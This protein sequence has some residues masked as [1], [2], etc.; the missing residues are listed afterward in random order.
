M[1]SYEST[2]GM[3]N[4]EFA[5]W[6]YRRFMEQ[7]GREIRARSMEHVRNGIQ[8]VMDDIRERMEWDRYVEQQVM[9]LI[10]DKFGHRALCVE[11][12]PDL[13]NSGL[14]RRNWAQADG[15]DF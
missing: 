5:D 15:R 2:E 12:A 7:H 11:E 8:R 3:S 10:W 13:S 14:L 6:A 1:S 9:C 4:G